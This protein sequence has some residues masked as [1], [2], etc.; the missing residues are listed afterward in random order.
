MQ[1]TGDDGDP[2]PPPEA[3]D[4]AVRVVVVDNNDDDGCD[5]DFEGP[6]PPKA[7]RMTFN[8]GV[9]SLHDDPPMLSALWFLW[10]NN[11]TPI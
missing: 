4:F 2:S 9:R 7:P 10:N 3:A 6:P 5:D 1:A 11:N 8:G